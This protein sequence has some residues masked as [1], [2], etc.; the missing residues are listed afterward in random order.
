MTSSPPM[1]IEALEL[2]NLSMTSSMG[3]NKKRLATMATFNHPLLDFD[4]THSLFNNNNNNNNNLNNLAPV[5]KAKTQPSSR[6]RYDKLDRFIIKTFIIFWLH[7][8]V[9]Y[10]AFFVSVFDESSLKNNVYQT[11]SLMSN[12][13]IY[14][15]Q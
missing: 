13:K 12:I 3:R 2:E 9:P 15:Q 6:I 8:L 5:A 14:V 7:L 4:A 11:I 10:L 1:S